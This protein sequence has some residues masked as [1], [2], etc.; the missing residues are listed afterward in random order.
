MAII[1]A[2]KI[3]TQP[4]GA[5]YNA[6][7]STQPV[8]QVG[9]LDTV[10]NAFTVDAGFVGTV[11]VVEGVGNAGYNLS[12]TLSVAFVAGVATF[13]NLGFVP[14]A[15]NS[16]LD[17]APASLSFTTTNLNVISSITFSISNASKLVITSTPIPTTAII[18]RTLQIPIK[19]QLK[20]SSNNSI[21]LDGVSIVATASGANVSGTTTLVT[22]ASGYVIFSALTFSSGAHVLISFGA[23]GLIPAI[24]EL[25][26]SYTDIIKPRRSIV[27]GKVPLSTDLVPFEI[28]INIPD[29]QLW[30]ADQTGTPILIVDGDA[31]VG[32]GSSTLLG[33]TDVV[34][35]TPADGQ[36]LKYNTSTSKWIND[37]DATGSGGGGSGTLFSTGST[38]PTTPAQGDRWVNTTDAVQYTYYQTA[39]VQFNN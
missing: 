33:L 37:T 14:D 2:L 23:P 24:L 28:C 13:T 20:D 17:I 35:T 38:A 3:L 19:L 11:L 9:N 1:K 27:A 21:P 25:D 4:Q 22:N 7:L 30:C 29:K 39:W 36:V 32:G 16:T 15:S 18:N 10:T 34:L 5:R 8:I 12:G 31:L 26:L 6:T